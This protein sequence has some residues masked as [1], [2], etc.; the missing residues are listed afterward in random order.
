[1]KRWWRGFRQEKDQREREEIKKVRD[2]LIATLRRLIQ[3][4]GHEGEAEYVAE[5]KR[6]KQDIG[7]EELRLRVR[8]YHSA[9]D[10]YQSRD[11]GLL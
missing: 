2:E 3:T 6:W 11:R 10:E 8:Q 4:R 9:V 5:L 1:M 7:P